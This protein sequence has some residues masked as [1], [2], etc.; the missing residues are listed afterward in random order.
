MVI[1]DGMIDFV[2]NTI[3]QKA[4]SIQINYFGFESYTFMP[5]N[6]KNAVAN[7]FLIEEQ[8]GL[9]QRD[10]ILRIKGRKLITEKDI[11]LKKQP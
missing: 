6:E 11:I 8:Q 5:Q 7:I 2:G 3:M 10:R 1:K 9:L 4:D